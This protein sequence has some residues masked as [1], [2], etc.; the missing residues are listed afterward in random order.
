VAEVVR[1]ARPDLAGGVAERWHD[2]TGG[3]PL[4]VRE[5]I[6][7]GDA[8]HSADATV[9]DSLQTVRAR[10]ERLSPAA[11]RLVEA[12]A[13]LGDGAPLWQAER[14]AGA[15]ATDEATRRE[16]VDAAILED[17]VE[18]C[19]THPAIREAVV[20]SIPAGDARRLHGAAVALLVDADAAPEVVARHLMAS[21][22]G[23]S[24]HAIA[25]LERAARRARLTGGPEQAVVWLRRAL[26]EAPTEPARSRLLADLAIAEAAAGDD[27]WSDTLER[28]A[29]QS[30]GEARAQLHLRVARALTHRGWLDRATEVLRAALDDPATAELGELRLELLAGL[31]VASRIDVSRRLHLDDELEAALAEADLD[32]SPAAR[33]VLSHLTYD[34]ALSACPAEDIRRM[35]RTAVLHPA[36]DDAE[37]LENVAGY[38]AVLALHFADDADAVDQVV[39]RWLDVATRRANETLFGLASNARCML[40]LAQGRIPD[41][42]DDGQSA[43]EVMCR[44]RRV[45]AVGAAGNLA[46]ALLERDEPE[47][48][49]AA[50]RLPDPEP[51]WR[52]SASFTHWLHCSGVVRLALGDPGGAEDLAEV[53]RRQRALGAANPATIPA[54]F[55]LAAALA[56]ERPSEAW[57]LFREA[58]AVAERFGAPRT[59]S[60][61]A[62]TRAVLE[63]HRAV[64]H[65]ERAESLVA[66]GPWAHDRMEARVA[67]GRGLVDLGDKQA[68]R[69]PL[70]AALAE[71]DS[72]GATRLARQ[73]RSLLLASGA[74]PRRAAVSG[75]EA[76]TPTERAVAQLAAE[77]LTN[78]EIAARRFVSVKAVEYQL[79]NV[80][81]KLA[82]SGRSELP[83]ALGPT[84]TDDR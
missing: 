37:V 14:L 42:V 5:L 6:R 9:D 63:P 55:V 40:R 54:P 23:T 80:F 31:A 73:A 79:A 62:R 17:D 25:V 58:E 78:R 52:A 4:F 70:R 2:L 30:P 20:R 59:L 28:A 36:V 38:Q 47:A 65:L 56:A 64:E 84:A 66:D 53:V 34:R 21:P 68:A 15:G 48:A 50:L 82:V 12:A 67:L 83:E 76:L 43:V 11:R 3:V 51:H 16:V 29:A 74:R 75:P 44:D 33:A 69:D 39:E 72:L 45:T 27:R 19:F 1:T 13:V 18:I 22:P 24:P 46:L 26:T 81:R 10:L 77:G 7:A 71:A 35:G 57:S 32:R 49:Q 60:V 41:A 61:A 8:L